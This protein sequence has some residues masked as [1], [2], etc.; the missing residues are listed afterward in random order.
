[1]AFIYEIVN[2]VNG[3]RYIGKTEF[4]INKRFA[5]HCKDAF[6]DRNEKRPLYSAMRKYGIEHFHVSL[7]EET[8][9]P[10]ERETY[11][12]NEKKTFH[13]GYNATLGGDGKRFLDYDL[14]TKTYQEM[15]NLKETAKYC[16]VSVD[17]VR[18][19]LRLNNIEIKSSSDIAKEMFQKSV[20]MYDKIDNDKLIDI[21][22]SPSEAA[23]YLIKNG[24]TTSS[25]N[26]GICAHI[27]QVCNGKRTSAYGHFWRYVN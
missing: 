21:F 1:M 16:G 4:D 23:S 13:Y 5:E 15:Q 26:K 10:E 6:K 18:N 7:I 3:K 2:D 14:I 19:I 8:E 20:A 9:H 24:L 11:W 27:I 12:I 22:V 25:N 17:S